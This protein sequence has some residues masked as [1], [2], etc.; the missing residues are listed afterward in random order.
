MRGAARPAGPG[1]TPLPVVPVWVQ[2]DRG[3]MAQSGKYDRKIIPVNLHLQCHDKTMPEA[4][5][6]GTPG[7]S[8][9]TVLSVLLTVTQHLPI[10][11]M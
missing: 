5:S 1:S 7:A 8:Q 9:K 4:T 11:F 2:G 3:S 6:I 10:A